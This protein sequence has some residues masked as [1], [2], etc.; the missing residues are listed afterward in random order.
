MQDTIAHPTFALRPLGHI[1]NSSHAMSSPAAPI[2]GPGCDQSNAATLYAITWLFWALS[3]V[4]IMA[5]IFTHAKLTKTLGWDDLVICLAWALNTVESA[6]VTISTS[7]GFDRH[8]FYLTPDEASAAAKWQIITEP[9]GI[10]S[11]TVTKIAITLLIQKMMS[12]STSGALF[13]W[14]INFIGLILAIVTSIIAFFR[15]QP[16][17]A[18]WLPIG[19]FHC[20]DP[21]ILIGFGVA[22]ASFSALGDFVL[23]LFPTSFL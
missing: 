22:S 4:F 19:D 23:A 7:Y 14:I 11:P 20:W 12:P 2:L 9:F 10:I 3:T 18:G 6:L 1:G 8:E 5:R 16:V 13:L 21:M 15:C 17:S